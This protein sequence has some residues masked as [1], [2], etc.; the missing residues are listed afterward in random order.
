MLSHLSLQS[1]QRGRYTLTLTVQH[2]QQS[3]R[4]DTTP[5]DSA[6]ILRREIH[7]HPSAAVAVIKSH[8]PLRRKMPTAT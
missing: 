6:P 4:A 1:Q 2:V 8:V 5:D 7:I 3:H